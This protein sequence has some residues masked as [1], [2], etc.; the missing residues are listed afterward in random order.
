MTNETVK[1]QR[2]RLIDTFLYGPL[3]IS[4]GLSPKPHPYLRAALI[5]LGVGTST[6]NY[7]NYLKIKSQNKS[8]E[9][10]NSTEIKLSARKPAKRPSFL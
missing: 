9:A 4:V 7:L 6:Y 3:M 10:A 5:I 1:S 8:P 2:V